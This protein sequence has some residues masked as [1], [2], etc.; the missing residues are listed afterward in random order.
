MTTNK[1]LW[2]LI[3]PT[4]SGKSTISNKI[5]RQSKNNVNI[6][7]WDTL[8]LEWYDSENY[9]N[10]WELASQDRNFKSRANE[11][12]C[13]LLEVGHDVIVDNTNLTPKRRKFF[14]QEAKKRG[15]ETI[16]VT[17]DVPLQTLIDRQ[18][19]RGDKCVPTHSVIKQFNS[20]VYPNV[21][22]FDIL[23][24]SNRII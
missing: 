23:M 5:V 11:E 22:E 21:D 9:A 14:I 3:G 8:R 15:Y 7:S 6:F 18:T 24:E 10:A 4:G 1:K 16:G 2:M 20:Y 19:T 12:F 17:F 13:R